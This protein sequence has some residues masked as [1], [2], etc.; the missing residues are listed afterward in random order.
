MRKAGG[1]STEGDMNRVALRELYGYRP[2]AIFMREV[3]A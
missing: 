3:R 2:A 1:N